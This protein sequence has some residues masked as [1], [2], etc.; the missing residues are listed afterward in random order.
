MINKL[1][2][3][4]KKYSHKYFVKEFM[5]CKP[6]KEYNKLENKQVWTRVS[7][8]ILMVILIVSLIGNFHLSACWYWYYSCILL[9]LCAVYAFVCW[10]LECR[11]MTVLSGMAVVYLEKHRDLKKKIQEQGLLTTE[12]DRKYINTIENTYR[13]DIVKR[14]LGE[15]CN[16]NVI[17]ALKDEISIKDVKFDLSFIPVCSLVALSIAI[18]NWLTTNIQERWLIAVVIFLVLLGLYSVIHLIRLSVWNFKCKKYKILRG[19]L[20]FMLYDYM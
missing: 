6:D 16:I 7:F 8:C 3:R 5:K 14:C 15:N 13:A 12:R 2:E 18:A 19:T 1:D 4:L 17:K 9:C 20:S 11:K 10:K